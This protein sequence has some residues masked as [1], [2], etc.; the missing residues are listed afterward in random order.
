MF[1]DLAGRINFCTSGRF[2]EQVVVGR[3]GVGY[4]VDLELLVGVAVVKDDEGDAGILRRDG[5]MRVKVE[6]IAEGRGV[7]GDRSKCGCCG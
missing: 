6:D 7:G 3:N 4:A 5:W 2:D 1:A